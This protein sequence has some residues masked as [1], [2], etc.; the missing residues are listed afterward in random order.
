[1]ICTRLPAV[2]NCKIRS[3]QYH[4]MPTARHYSATAIYHASITAELCQ[5]HATY[6]VF[7]EYFNVIIH[8]SYTPILYDYERTLSNILV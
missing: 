7:E 3:D 1:M 8:N 6:I 4:S 5:Y 2:V